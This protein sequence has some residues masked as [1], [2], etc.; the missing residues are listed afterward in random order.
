MRMRDLCEK[1][2]AGQIE[3]NLCGHDVGD[4][5]SQRIVEYYEDEVAGENG[6]HDGKWEQGTTDEQM[7]E[8]YKKLL[9]RSC[10]D[11][12]RASF[13]SA[14]FQCQGCGEKLEWVLNGNT[15]YLSS[16]WTGKEKVIRPLDFVCPYATLKP[17]VG[18]IQVKG[19]LVFANFFRHVENRPEK[20]DRSD[21]SINF[22]RGRDNVSQYKAERG[23]AMGIMGNM[24]IGIF[25]HPSLRS[26]IIGDI[27]ANDQFEG[28]SEE[29]IDEHVNEHGMEEADQIDG[30]TL[31]GQL[32]LEMWR[33]EATDSEALGAENLQKTIEEFGEDRVF[34]LNV[35][36][37]TWQFEHYYD[38]ETGPK[39]YIY[40]KLT[41][42]ED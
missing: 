19:K 25:L 5:F 16:Y 27:F 14:D 22:F 21:W 34:L 2:K 18:E 33:W 39:E 37:G 8:V 26:I 13:F 28:M 23:V 1:I 9:D 20:G 24:S 15:L 30:H 4:D 17:R 12:K 11:G 41:L 7:R 35:D 42:K 38:T 3:F 6:A 31:V 32:S 29:E 10:E 36:P 40:S